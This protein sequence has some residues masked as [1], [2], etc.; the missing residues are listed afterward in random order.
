MNY[1]I[2]GI[3]GLMGGVASGLFGIGG[4]VVMVPAMTLLMGMNVKQ[5]IGTSLAVII[6]TALAGVIKHASQEQMDWR[7]AF[8][9][10]PTAILGSYGGAWLT[11]QI[12]PENLKRGFGVVLILVGGRLLLGK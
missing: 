11:T 12:A 3:I 2:A 7:A 10:A 6:P 8:M 9:L 5:A 1:L 4:G